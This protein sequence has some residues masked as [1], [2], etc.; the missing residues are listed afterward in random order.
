MERKERKDFNEFRFGGLNY[1]KISNNYLT[2][3]RVSSDQTKIVVR[4]GSNHLIKTPYGYALVLDS[5]R[6]VFLKEWQVSR[7]YYGNEVLLD[8]N[9][10][11]VKTWGNHEL[12]SVD[13]ESTKFET[14][15][16]AAIEQKETEV[17][18]ENNKQ[19]EIKRI[20]YGY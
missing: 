1:R 4:V 20:M 5:T 18:W 8:K 3:D 19:K 13:E 15:L 10:F 7:N 17:M 11:N 6:V 16:A 9:Y 2:M 12:F 14:W